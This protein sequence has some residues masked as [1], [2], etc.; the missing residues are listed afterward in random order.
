MLLSLVVA[1]SRNGVIGKDNGLPWR[2][3]ADLAH[4][5]RLTLGHPI[6]M[7]R[8]TWES[9][10]RALPGRRNIVVTRTP[11]YRAPG[12]EVVDSLDAAWRASDGAAEVF[13]IG[14]AALYESVLPFADRIFLT[15]V[16]ADVSGDTRFPALDP[17]HWR[18]TLLGSHSADDRNPHAMRFL[19]LERVPRS[20]D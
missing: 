19:L 8:R 16:D 14:G 11:G 2:L 15:E 12:A 1:R 17:R 6:V 13:V 9:I 20:G 3:P 4:F 7:G 10:G 5:K 18:Q